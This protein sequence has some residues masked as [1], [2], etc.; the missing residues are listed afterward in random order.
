MYPFPLCFISYSCYKLL[1]LKLLVRIW[2]LLGFFF[3]P[4]FGLFIPYSSVSLKLEPFIPHL[5]PSCGCAGLCLFS[6][7]GLGH[8]EMWCLQVSADSS[9]KMG[10]FQVFFPPTKLWGFFTAAPTETLS[11]F[12]PV[13]FKHS[14]WLFPYLGLSSASTLLMVFLLKW[15]QKV[16]CYISLNF[17]CC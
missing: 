10:R 6:R 14:S 12:L 15:V 16:S 8:R 2:G 13:S 1:Y 9:L 11:F 17:S 7:C 5:F 3:F 4:S